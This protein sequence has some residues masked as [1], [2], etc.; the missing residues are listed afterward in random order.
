[1]KQPTMRRRRRRSRIYRTNLKERRFAGCRC[2]VFVNVYA[3]SRFQEQI[4]CLS[5]HNAELRSQ[6]E[7]LCSRTREGSSSSSSSS[8][9]GSS[10]SIINTPTAM[11]EEGGA[12][13]GA[14][15]SSD[16]SNGSSRFEIV[17]EED[18]IGAEDARLA[19]ANEKTDGIA[20][21]VKKGVHTLGARGKIDFVKSWRPNFSIFSHSGGG[22]GDGGPGV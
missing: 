9:S 1:M 15:S 7:M 2:E 14:A 16:S 8:G 4:R 10:R 11:S 5:S 20:E 19:D 17:G 6:L 18:V 13:G 3:C 12:A 22:G 21:S